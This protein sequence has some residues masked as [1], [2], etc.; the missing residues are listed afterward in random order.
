MH[1]RRMKFLM[2][3][4]GFGMPFTRHLGDAPFGR[5]PRAPRGNVRGAILVLLGEAPMHGY[6]IIQEL[7]RRSEGAWKPSP[8][9]I[10]PTLQVLEDEGL[11]RAEERDGRRVFRLT[12][13]GEAHLAEH[14][15]QIGT[16][17]EQVADEFT[18][19]GGQLQ[20]SVGQLFGAVR[21]VSM[22][23]TREQVEQAAKVL[24]DARRRLYLILADDTTPEPP[25]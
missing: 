18:M 2:G 6:Q 5:G 22:S 1:E 23:G 10:Y 3:G 8:G 19:R 9:S 13:T 12:E 14:R 16:P 17:W 7:E 11:V 24:A 4:P 20:E 15:D 25:A 21:Q